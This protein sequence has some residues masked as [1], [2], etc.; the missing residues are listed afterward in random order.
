MEL[1]EF[2]PA[3]FG[4]A[5]DPNLEGCYREPVKG[6]PNLEGYYPEPTEGDPNLWGSSPVNIARVDTG[7]VN[8]SIRGNQIYEG[9]NGYGRVVGTIEGN[10]IYKGLLPCGLPELTL[11]DDGHIY[12]GQFAC[13]NCIGRVTDSG[14][15]LGGYGSAIEQLKFT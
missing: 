15:A 2:D 11:D 14:I 5:L 4:T 10:H 9:I 13:G 3:R 8:Y 6:D 7:E 12:T 1:I